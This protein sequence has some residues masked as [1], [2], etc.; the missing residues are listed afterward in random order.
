[1]F[2]GL[3]Y[4]V[5]VLVIY[6]QR[7]FHIQ[8]HLVDSLLCA[9]SLVLLILVLYLLIL[10]PIFLAI[11]DFLYLLDIVLSVYFVYILVQII[12]INIGVNTIFCSKM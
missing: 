5:V 9:L 4:N 7:V 12:T 11:C 8:L 1:M 6:I 10:C 2:I 3:V